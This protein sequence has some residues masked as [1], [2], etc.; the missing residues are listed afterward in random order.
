[1]GA[2]VPHPAR[3]RRR[4]PSR[5]RHHSGDRRPHRRP[6]ATRHRHAVH[7]ARAPCRRRPDR[8]V[9][10]PAG[11]RPGRRP[12]S[13][14]QADAHRPRGLAR[15]GGSP[16][17]IGSAGSPERRPAG[18]VPL[19]IIVT[20]RFIALASRAYRASLYLCPAALRRQYGADMRLAF[21]AR[22]R[23][24]SRRGRLAMVA[25]LAGE[26][27]DLVIAS[28]LSHQHRPTRS[29]RSAERRSIVG[30]LWQDA[31]YGARMLRRQPGFAAVAVITL[32]LGIGAS[33]AVFTVVNGVLL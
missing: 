1:L 10:A 12:A 2:A 18:L 21:E 30:G 16:R 9:A 27:W 7:G 29:N 8:G 22:C 31:R 24:A 26:I 19:E 6:G 33:T 14:L 3:A 23:D 20:P 5:L 17:C 13:I 25:V 32:A 28:A 11:G 4:G 15:R